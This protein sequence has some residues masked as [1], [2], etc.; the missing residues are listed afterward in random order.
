MRQAKVLIG[1]S[2]QETDAA[3][4]GFIAELEGFGQPWGDDTLGSLIGLSYQGIFEVAMDCF[5]SNLDLIDEYAERLGVAADEIDDT[6]THQAGALD[7]VR[8]RMPDMPV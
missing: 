7:Q 2:T 6:D 4:S 8:A 3:L 1:G 5:A